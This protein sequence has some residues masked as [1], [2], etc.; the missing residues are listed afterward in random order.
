M[1]SLQMKTYRSIQ[2]VRILTKRAFRITYFNNLHHDMFFLYPRPVT[3]EM[4]V[5]CRQVGIRCSSH[6]R[7]EIYTKLKYRR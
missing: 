2:N 4:P 5:L 7:L 1:K 3:P 6:L